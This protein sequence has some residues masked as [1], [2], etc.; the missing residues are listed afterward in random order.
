[1]KEIKTISQ[2]LDAMQH[3]YRVQKKQT[4]KPP[5]YHAQEQEKDER[6]FCV[7]LAGH[8]IAIDSIYSEVYTLCKDYISESEP[9]M[10]IV[11][12]NSDIEHEYE[13]TGRDKASNSNSYM[14]TL[15]VYRKICEAILDYNIFLMHG[16]V[17]AVGDAAYMF[18]A[19]SG[20]GKTT[21]IKKWLKRLENAIVVNGDKPLIKITEKEVIACGTPWCGKEHLGNNTMV[22]LKAIVFMERKEDNTIEEISF[23]DGLGRL[24]QQAYLPSDTEKVKKTIELLSQLSGKVKFY[25]Y[26]FNNMKEDAFDVSYEALTGKKP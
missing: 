17:V 16:A 4:I 21:H 26:Y 11:V 3:G 20:T 25:Q 12:C 5:I 2:L 15:V 18:T 9:E 22:P 7:S 6:H 13:I 10:R 8:T 14:E 1:M 24:I 23:S 19:Q